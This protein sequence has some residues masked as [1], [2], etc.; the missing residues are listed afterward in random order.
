MSGSACLGKSVL[1]PLELNG[2]H[3]L[4]RP[5]TFIWLP[6]FHLEVAEFRGHCTLYIQFLKVLGG[7]LA[8]FIFERNFVFNERQSVFCFFVFKGAHIFA[9]RRRSLHH[10]I[11]LDEQLCR[12]I[13]KEDL[14]FA[15]YFLSLGNSVPHLDPGSFST[16]LPQRSE[17][18]KPDT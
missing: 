15:S 14:S 3:S 5:R 13:P 17:T 9:R 1:C 11:S 6:L 4:D 10:G 16:D 8:H 18:P 12:A 7:W 2:W